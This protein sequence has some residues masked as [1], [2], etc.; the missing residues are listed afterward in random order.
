MSYDFS[1]TLFRDSLFTPWGFRLEG[2]RDYLTPLAIQRVCLIN[3]LLI[4][5]EIYQINEFLKQVF[6]GSP[7]S[8]EL[9][10]GD[11]IL[12][13]QNRDAS[14]LL[15]KE[16]D[17]LIRSSGGSITLTIRRFVNYYV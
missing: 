10:R 16:A 3:Y 1:V 6:T 12:A 2:G 8:T 13:I 11:I 4:R 17:D 14:L 5:F 9:Q 15:H 7:A